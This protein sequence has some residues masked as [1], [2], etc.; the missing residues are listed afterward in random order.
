MDGDGVMLTPTDEYAGAFQNGLRNGFGVLRS[1]KTAT[2]YEGHWKNGDKHG[3][4][5]RRV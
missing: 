4:G 3:Q 1:L 2:T 5:T